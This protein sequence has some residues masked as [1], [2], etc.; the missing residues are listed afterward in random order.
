MNVS[1]LD[2]L[3]LRAQTTVFETLEA[4][5]MGVA[6]ISEP[7]MPAER[8]RLARTTAGFFGMLRTSPILGRVFSASDETP[9]AP[10]VAIL[11]YQVWRTRYNGIPGR[12]RTPDPRQRA[13][14]DGD[15]RHARRASGCRIARTC[16][17]RSRP[18]S[19]VRPRDA[20]GLLVIGLMK[21][22]VTMAQASTDLEVVAKRLADGLSRSEP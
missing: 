19:V 5:S 16:G 4:A 17:F 13:A 20:R 11:G 22:G 9:G 3:D 14:G 6:T 21:P 1:W 7:D 2:F 10:P 8:Y 15:R 12:D 18:S